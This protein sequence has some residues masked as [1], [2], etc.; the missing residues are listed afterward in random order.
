MFRDA[1]I[2]TL[3]LSTSLLAADDHTAARPSKLAAG[4]A[5]HGKIEFQQCS[6]CHVGGVA[7]PVLTGLFKRK[8]MRDKKRTPLTV[9]SVRQRIVS[10]GDGMPPFVSLKPKQVDDLIAY[11]KTL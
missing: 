4:N 9:D 6:S 5:V 3:L 11:L 7:G 1:L 2:L 8:S 10:G